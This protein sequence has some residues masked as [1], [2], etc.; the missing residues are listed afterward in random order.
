MRIGIVGAGAIARSHLTEALAEHPG[1]VVAAVCDLNA[2]VAEE[3]AGLA[4]GATAYKDWEAMLGGGGAGRRSSSARR[5]RHT[6]SRRPAAFERGIPSTSRSRSRDRL[7]DGEAIVSAWRASGVPCA[8]GYQWRSLDVLDR[9]PRRAG[10][11]VAR[12]C[13]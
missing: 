13:S 11:S 9:A 10:R 1:D 7:A 5:R 12:A 6:S 4:S 8:V 3:T 2:D